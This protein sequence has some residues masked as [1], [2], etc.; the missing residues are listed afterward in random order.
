MTLNGDTLILP[1][2]TIIEKVYS[3]SFEENERQINVAFLNYGSQ[4]RS[5]ADHS[6]S[7]EIRRDFGRRILQQHEQDLVTMASIPVNIVTF[8]N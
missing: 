7:S 3:F 5:G 1:C 4:E 8:S 6:F 2:G